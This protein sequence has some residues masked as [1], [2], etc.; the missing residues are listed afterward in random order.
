MNQASVR[1]SN[2]ASTRC[3]TSLVELL[4]ADSYVCAVS[5]AVPARSSQSPHDL[6]SC[7]HHRDLALW[8]ALSRRGAPER[9]PPGAKQSGADAQ[10]SEMQPP[11]PQRLLC[12][13]AST[14]P[15]VPSCL[16]IAFVAA[17]PLLGRFFNFDQAQ[18]YGLAHFDP[19]L[20]NETGRNH[21]K[22][23]SRHQFIFLAWAIAGLTFVVWISSSSNP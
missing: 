9:R 1:P 2:S 10:P 21:L 17:I 12:A 16:G 20:L 18:A 11:Q 22:R 13:T 14:L 23:V 19:A 3:I 4:G 15:F 5:M 7:R 6:S 8:P